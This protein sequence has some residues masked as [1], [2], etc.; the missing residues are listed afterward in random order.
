MANIV[1]RVEFGGPFSRTREYPL[2]EA[3]RF[4]GHDAG[5]LAGMAGRS[6]LV[7][8]HRVRCR[9]PGYRSGTLLHPSL[10]PSVSAVGWDH[11]G[12]FSLNGSVR[13]DQILYILPKPDPAGRTAL[14]LSA[15]EFLD[16]LA[17]ILPP[18]RLHRHRYHGVFAPNAPLRPLVTE[19]A[20]EDNA[21][22]AEAH[23]AP[24]SPPTPPRPRLPNQ[25][26]Q[27][28]GHRIPPPPG[29]PGG[30][31]SWPGSMKSSR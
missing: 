21:L 6:L 14:C 30:P 22:A 11:G 4:V 5:R 9:D 15:L 1:S 25:R 2:E 24:L 26:G 27:R 8:V 10:L 18:P 19:R 20:R 16:R 3:L 12:G 13:S 31:P 17:T 7:R 29:H 28:C 23:G